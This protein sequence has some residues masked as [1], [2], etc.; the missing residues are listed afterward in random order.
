MRTLE[1][2]FLVDGKGERTREK[3]QAMR[4]LEF[5]DWSSQ[6]VK[7][8]QRDVVRIGMTVSHDKRAL[9]AMVDNLLEDTKR[10][11]MLPFSTL[12]EVFPKLVRD[13][14][15]DRNKEVDLII[16]GDEIE[17][18]RRILE[19]MKDP[20]MH[21]VRNCI[22]HGMRKQASESDWGRLLAAP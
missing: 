19:E 15:R 20:L 2:S 13:L 16:Q 9:G 21:L 7:S 8:L 6:F 4:L 17:I 14:S 12:L 3:S 22:D 11:L 10:A 1:K 18:D 5:L